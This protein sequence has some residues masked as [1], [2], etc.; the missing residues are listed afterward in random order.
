M[1]GVTWDVGIGI[2]AA[3]LFV[4]SFFIRRHKA[5]A[6]VVSVYVAFLIAQ[7]WGDPLAELF[8]G[9]RVIFNNVWIQGNITPFVVKISLLSLL[10]VLLS[11]FMKL[12]GRRSR[13]GLLEVAVYTVSLVAL[14]LTYALLL[15]PSDMRIAIAEDS[16]VVRFLIDW[17]DWV[18]VVP[19]FAI[20]YF[21]IY[22]DEEN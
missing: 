12:G 17:K 8:S 2:V 9:D 11:T 16:Y 5:L 13:Y 4:Y 21:G 1:Q 10:V 18:Q 19:V 3:I 22:G 15:M 20:I 14:S 7:N 6:T